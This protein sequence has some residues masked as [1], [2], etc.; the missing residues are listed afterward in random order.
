MLLQYYLVATSVKPLNH[1]LPFIT[2]KSGVTRMKSQ[3]GKITFYL[4]Q[5]IRIAL[6]IL[7]EMWYFR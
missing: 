5:R 3:Q 7:E 4:G 1:V 6:N 2:L